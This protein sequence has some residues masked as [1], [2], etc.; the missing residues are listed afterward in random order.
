MVVCL[1][2]LSKLSSCYKMPEIIAA[3]RK[4]FLLKITVLKTLVNGLEARIWN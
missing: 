1:I 3:K 2:E 4:L